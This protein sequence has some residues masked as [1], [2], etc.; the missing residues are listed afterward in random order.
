LQKI[1]S[2][3]DKWRFVGEY[4]RLPE[5]VWDIWQCS[6][7]EQMFR[8]ALG[9]EMA[10]GER[11]IGHL[12]R[13]LP[14]VLEGVIYVKDWMVEYCELLSKVHGALAAIRIRLELVE[15]GAVGKNSKI[16]RPLHNII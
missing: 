15:N 7:S 14:E 5:I 1:G 16:L 6:G 12:I 10:Q 3:I 9:E 13:I 8:H 2:E 4:E 11:Y